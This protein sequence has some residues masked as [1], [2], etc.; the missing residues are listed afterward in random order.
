[1]EP[2][3]QVSQVSTPHNRKQFQHEAEQYQE[4]DP[5]HE[6]GHRNSDKRYDPSN[7]VRRSSQPGGCIDP[8]R[9]AEQYTDQHTSKNQI[10]GIREDLADLLDNG[11]GFDKFRELVAAQGGDVTMVDDPDK[12]PHAQIR[13]E[14]PAKQSGFIAQINALLV[15]QAS[16]EL[17]AGRARKED[18]I[19]LSV[20]VEVLHKV[21]DRVEAG[22]VMFAIHAN[23][24][25][26]QVRELEIML[27][28]AESFLDS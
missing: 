23:D 14:I 24:Q 5:Q 25:A 3:A 8:Q 27:K 19:D 12:L 15:A 17:G 1:M 9:Y 7:I 21:G 26:Q 13:E 18:S 10:Q 16:L 20:G 2:L 28:V 4:H 22:D 11:A 6:F